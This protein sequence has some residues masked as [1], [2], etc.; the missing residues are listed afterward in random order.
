[1]SDFIIKS[2]AA[3]FIIVCM[4]AF[5][6][7]VRERRKAKFVEESVDPYEANATA[8]APGKCV[9]VEDHGGQ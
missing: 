1:M 3:L 8:R 5:G 4:L 2:V 9:D 7:V 6:Q